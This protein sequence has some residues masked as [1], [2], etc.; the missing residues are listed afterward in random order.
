MR[1]TVV[2]GAA[3]RGKAESPLTSKGR[4]FESPMIRDRCLRVRQHYPA[5]KN[6][7]KNCMYILTRGTTAVLRK[8]LNSSYV[9]LSFIEKQSYKKKL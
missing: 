6:S 9:G 4:V 2:R 5:Q 8:E 1:R 7:Q 3:G